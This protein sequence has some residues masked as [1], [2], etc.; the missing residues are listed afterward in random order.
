MNILFMG[1]P[2]FA[3]PSLEA[4]VG[5]GHNI[6]AVVT[7]PD[8]PTGRGR[9][10]TASPVK[11][12]AER[13]RLPLL[14]PAKINSG[15]TVAVLRALNP[16]VIVVVA[17]GAI[18]RRPL[19]TLAPLGAVNVHASVLPA[20]RGMAPV[21]WG[22][23]QGERTAGVTTMLMDEGVDTG[24]TL[25]RMITDVHPGETSGELLARLADIGATL[26][27][28]TLQGLKEGELKAIP[29]PDAG[30][31]Y[32]PRLEREHGYLDLTRSATEVFNQFRGITPSPGARVFIG[33]D[34]ILVR[35]MRPVP[36]VS[37]SPYEIL[38]IGDRHVRIGAG[39]DAVDL[40]Q[41]R[42]P[43]KNDMDGAAF[44]RGRDLQ[45]GTRLKAPTVP[46]LCLRTAVAG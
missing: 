15:E 11:E 23:I 25:E 17:F 18:L 8:R 41:V 3:A 4:L 31:S 14:Q 28:S 5:A 22:L 39:T 40:I 44:A 10:L 34:P 21:Q 6:L 27:G 24:P 1:T 36:G 42:P 20:Y 29:Q 12:V 9:K 33:E 30:V 38:E 7:R 16:S 19:L 43:G 37:G 46:D 13:H 32:A 2:Q 26:L 35:A 45:L